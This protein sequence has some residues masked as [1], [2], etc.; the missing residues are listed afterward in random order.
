MNGAS[1][2]T[3]TARVGEEYTALAATYD[4]DWA[5]YNRATAARTRA[6]LEAQTRPAGPVLNVGCGTDPAASTGVANTV[7]LDPSA[8]MLAVARGRHPG[9]L[10]RGDA[11]ALPFAGGTFAAAVTNSALH[12]L[13][14]PAAAVREL[15][16]VLAPGAPCVWTDWNGGSLTTQAVCFWLSKIGRPLGTVLTSSEM[17]NAMTNAGFRDVRT[18]RWRHGLLWGLATVSGVK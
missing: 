18:D 1:R 11:A 16:R 4:R 9:P 7:G 5:A 8:A 6:A 3:L 17:A 13:G 10:V 15:H 2:P 12:Y 14:D